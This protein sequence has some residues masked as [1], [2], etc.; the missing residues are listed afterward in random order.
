[1]VLTGAAE[2][3]T[4]NVPRVS[5]RRHTCCKR[6][7]DSYS[8]A[9][10][11]IDR[12]SQHSRIWQLHEVFRHLLHV[13]YT[14]TKRKYFPRLT[15]STTR[16]RHDHDQVKDMEENVA[17]MEGAASSKLVCGVSH[18]SAPHPFP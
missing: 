2:P 8:L 10:D 6:T 11:E 4:D 1:M 3:A 7:C 18:K 5:G 17:S 16:K 14:K 15:R 9:A 13:L 12:S